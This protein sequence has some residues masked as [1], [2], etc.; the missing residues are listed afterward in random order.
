LICLFCSHFAWQTMIA[1]LENNERE[2][3]EFFDQGMQVRTN[4]GMRSTMRRIGWSTNFSKR[5]KNESYIFVM[6][7]S[8]SIGSYSICHELK[9]TWE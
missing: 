8:W 9:I 6:A 7:E 5:R 2:M 3:K 4:R 1:L